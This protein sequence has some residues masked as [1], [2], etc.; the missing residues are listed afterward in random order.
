[1]SLYTEYQ[2]NYV[3]VKVISGTTSI[4]CTFLERI[5]GAIIIDNSC[6]ATIIYGPNCQ[7][8]TNLT[9]QIITD[10]LIS[11]QLTSFLTQTRATRL[12]YCGF[13]V[14]VTAGEKFLTVEG[15]IGKSS[16]KIFA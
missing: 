2:N 13:V 5:T 16:K 12:A 7:N 15:N 1:M 3:T 9:G 10:N 8:Q 6:N 11:I 14:N 4:N